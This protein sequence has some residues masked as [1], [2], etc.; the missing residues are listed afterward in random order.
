MV[1][2]RSVNSFVYVTITCIGASS[3]TG[4]DLQVHKKDVT[5]LYRFTNYTTTHPGKI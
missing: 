3:L 2:E 4:V 5:V 1:E